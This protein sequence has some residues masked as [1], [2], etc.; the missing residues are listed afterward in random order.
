MYYC[1][2][3]KSVSLTSVLPVMFILLLTAFLCYITTPIYQY[4]PIFIA[5]VGI[6]S[7]M[8]IL[9]KLTKTEYEYN[10]EGDLFTIALIRNHSSRKILFASD[11]SNLVS[12]SPQKAADT[13]F[14]PS[15][16]IVAT[17]GE[18]TAYIALFSEDETKTAITFS[19][20]NEFIDSLYL[21]AP[22][23]VNRNILN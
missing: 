16:R 4:L 5:A 14:T 22:R 1:T 17:A 6:I 10:I 11:I 21:L 13:N 15:K 7:S 19:P 20:S 9:P 18:N 12:C 3:K 23:K 2:V 8:I